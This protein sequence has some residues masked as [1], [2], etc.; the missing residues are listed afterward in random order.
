MKKMFAVPCLECGVLVRGR[1]RCDTH[2]RK[3]LIKYEARRNREHYKGDY[4]TRAKRVR[5]SAT[6]CW[7]CLEG[8]LDRAEITA[9]HYDAGDPYSPLLP[10]H[11][12]CNSSRQALPPDMIRGRVQK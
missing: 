2:Y 1:N 5:E 10:A 3:Y 7:I 9:D 8:F 6:V 12:S 4:Q 11:K